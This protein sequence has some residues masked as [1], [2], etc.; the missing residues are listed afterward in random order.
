ML[1]F[2]TILGLRCYLEAQPTA[3]I[4]FVP[5]MG[6]LHQG[7]RSL[8]DRARQENDLVIVSIFINPLQFA[9]G[10]DLDKYP[11]QLAADQQLCTE[12]GV[13]VIFNPTS[14]SL[15][16]GEAITQVVP[17]ASL[18]SG[19][20]GRSRP[21]HFTGV[22]TIVTKLLQIIRPTNSYFGQKDAQ[23]VAIIRKLAQDLYLP[24]RIVTCPIVRAA[25]GLALSSRNQ[26]LSDTQQEQATNIY[27]SLQQAQDL[28]TKGNSSACTSGDRSTNN[29]LTAVR[30]TLQK[31]PEIELDYLELVDPQTMAP[32]D[33]IQTSG[34]L[35][36]AAK[37]GNTRLIDNILLTKQ[38]PIIAIDGPA[39]AGKSTVTKLVAKTLGLQFLDTGAMY[40]AVTWLV[41]QAHLPLDSAAEIAELVAKS[42]IE[43][44]GDR[45]LINGQNIS[46]EIR[47][48]EVTSK[49]SAIAAL[50]A[51]RKALVQQQQSIGRNGGIVAEG[52]DMCT[53]VFPDA[54]VKIFLTATVGERARR[55]L[56]DLH[57]SGDIDISLTELEASIAERDR[58]DSTRAIAPLKKAATATEIV[59]DGMSIEQVVAEIVDMYWAYLPA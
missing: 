16:L 34:L 55:R 12:A 35:A 47:S 22:A 32:L 27:L 13:D 11:R 48:L 18:T 39:G 21:G 24:G 5:T 25:S 26:Y 49:V 37:V 31:H 23:Q 3:T 54:G 53:H 58:L 50:G 57:A 14:E 8:I 40:R 6:A 20:C 1:S 30:S 52:R 33:S 38:S 45:V 46:T 44:Q 43:L 19:L 41:L 4:G 59:T 29:L 51:V 56:A 10:E 36:I 42:K 17:A 9:P 28:F 7:H 2:E 15:N